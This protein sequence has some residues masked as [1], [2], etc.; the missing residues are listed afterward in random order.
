MAAAE[1]TSSGI[2][3][4]R[5]GLGEVGIWWWKKMREGW[6]GLREGGGERRGDGD[7]EGRSLNRQILWVLTTQFACDLAILLL[8]LNFFKSHLM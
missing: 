8:W 3:G 4:E 7:G 1:G 2:G 5:E 6:G